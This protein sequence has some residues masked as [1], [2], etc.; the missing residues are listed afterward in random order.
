MLQGTDNDKQLN[1]SAG[2]P[3]SAISKIQ[4]FKILGKYRNPCDIKPLSTY[5]KCI[6]FRFIYLFQPNLFNNNKSNFSEDMVHYL[7][8]QAEINVGTPDIFN[9]KYCVR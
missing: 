7:Y 3:Q 1:E 9:L 6:L 8:V 5:Q 2:Y 4:M